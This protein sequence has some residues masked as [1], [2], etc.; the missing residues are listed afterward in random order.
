MGR[1]MLGDHQR[2]RSKTDV[3]RSAVSVGCAAGRLTGTRG[4]LE[5]DVDH[6]HRDVGED[7]E[8]RRQSLHR[9]VGDDIDDPRRAHPSKADV[10]RSA[11]SVGFAAGRLT[12]TRGTWKA[13]DEHCLDRSGRASRIHVED[14][15][16]ALPVEGG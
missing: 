2:N 1:A 12:G 5:A 4:G 10:Q 6:S 9:E 11:V 8:D 15:R 3:Q 14:P 7:I 13:D 16:R